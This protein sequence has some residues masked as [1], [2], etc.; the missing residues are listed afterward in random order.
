MVCCLVF[1]QCFDFAPISTITCLYGILRS[2]KLKNWVKVQSTTWYS[3]IFMICDM[4]TI[5]GSNIFWSLESLSNIWTKKLRPITGK[6]K[7]K[8][9][10]YNPCKYL[11]GLWLV[12][13]SSC[14]LNIDNVLVCRLEVHCAFGHAWIYAEWIWFWKT[15]KMVKK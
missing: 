5:C 14:I 9:S 2:R 7:H 4:M 8:I 6:K 13:T 12:Q 1:A 15:S 3:Q 10:I 11:Y